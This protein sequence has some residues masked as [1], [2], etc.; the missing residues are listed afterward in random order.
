MR[1][2]IRSLMRCCAFILVALPAFAQT[3]H[4][5]VHRSQREQWFLRGRTL[6]GRPSAELLRRAHAQKLAL[7]AA[8]AANPANATPQNSSSWTSL[9]PAPL[10]SDASGIGQ[11]DYNWVSGRATAVA[12]DPADPSANTVYLGGAYGGVWKSTNATSP[13]PGNVI[14]T[15][16]IDDQATL[17]VGA[18]AIQPGGTGVIVVGTGEA[19]S[20]TDSYYGLGILLSSNAGATWTLI[21]SDSTGTR[22]FAGMAFSKIAFSTTTPSL[23]VAATAGASEGILEG[24]ANPVTANLGLYGSTDGG[25]Q[26]WT[27]GN[28]T[29]NGVTIDPGSA[30]AVVFNPGAGVFFAALRYHG[31]YSSPDGLNWI[32]L[33]NQPGAG[34]TTAACP[35]NPHSPACPIY[36]GEIAVVPGRNEMYAWY[37]DANN[38]DQGIWTSLDGGKTW[39]AINES[40]ITNCG[41]VTGCGTED[42][43]Y[44]LELAAVPD[45]GATDLYAGAVNLYK[46]QITSFS[47]TCAGTGQ[48]TFLNL[49]HAYGCSAIARVHPGQHAVAFQLTNSNTQD[50]MYFANDGGLYRALNGYT[51][52]TTGA[53]GSSNQF[54]SL[55]QT[56]GSMTQLVSF[57]QSATDPNTVLAGAGANGSPA[58]QSALSNSPWLNVNSGDGGNTQINPLDATDWFVSNPP[59]FTSGTNIFRCELGINCLT[60]DFQNDQVVNSATLG[61]DTGAYYPSFLLDPQ[62]SGELVVGTCRMWRGSSSGD[63]FTPL[64]NNFETGGSGICTGAETNL[65][66]SAAAAGPL[67]ANGFSNVMYAGTDGFGPLIPTIPSGGHVWVSTNVASGAVTWSDQTGAINPD[68]FPISGI[69]IDT[70]DPTGLTAYV[71]IMGFLVSHVWK[72]TNGGVSWMDFTANLPD[73]PANAVVV[74]PATNS[75]PGIIYVGTDVGVFSSRTASANW[76]EVGPAPS[77]GNP[78]F[79]PN[80]AVTTLQISNHAAAKLLRASTY[81]RGLWQF[82]VT[83]FAPTVLNNPIVAFPATLPATFSGFVSF[84]NYN[85][86]VNLTC[87]PPQQASCF[88][89]GSPVSAASPSFTVTASVTGT[90]ASY[91]FDLHAVGNDPNHSTQDTPLTLNL[92][93]FSLGP[94][95]AGSVTVPPGASSGPITFKVTLS[96][97]LPG[98]VTLS[99]LN[100]PQGV[101]CNFSPA[102]SPTLTPN[103]STQITLTLSVAANT[104]G[105]FPITVQ[106]LLQVTVGETVVA[107]PTPKTQNLS[108]VVPLDYALNISNPSLTVHEGNLAV[109][110]NGTLTSLN[111]YDSPVNLSCGMGAPPT[112]TAAPATVT[113]TANGSP[114]TVTVSTP[115]CGQYNFSILAAGTDPL[116]TSHS[117]PVI[118]VSNRPNPSFT[119]AISNSPLAADVSVPATFNGTLFASACYDY[120]VQ[121][122]CGSG[123]PP[124]CTAS[125]KVVTPTDTGAAFA[126]TVSSTTAQTYNFD[127]VGQGSDPS[128]LLSKQL[129]S[130]TSGSSAGSN[131]IFTLT[132]NSGAESVAAG[133]MATF[134]LIVAA[135]N[136]KLPDSVTINVSGCPAFSTCTPSPATVSAGEP[137]ASVALQIQT[138]TAIAIEHARPPSSRTPA[139][140]A[141]SLFLPGLLFTFSAGW[142]RRRG[143]GFFLSLV[144]MLIFLCCAL[145]CGGG[146]QGSSIADPQPGTTPS[147]YLLTVTAAMNSAPGS[148]T[149]TVVVVLT[150][151]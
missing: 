145:S 63:G 81:G 129:V 15:P 134:N 91:S 20:S 19:N 144:A 53:C 121:L 61:G 46:C 24:L 74:D 57:S 120:P 21:P 76:T 107:D 62:N 108:L 9:G 5:D 104:A 101:Q 148:P 128:A 18:I 95:S 73:A 131:S 147:T 64:S 49:T 23:A 67:D 2:S 60:P 133:Q 124:S 68:A 34:L 4:P 8:Q 90:D 83:G 43:A 33:T 30:T 42:G 110:F 37:V 146:L 48:N 70:S 87:V 109:F 118:F 6:P 93:D 56:L 100:P 47:P 123:S 65:V 111:G 88:V 10:S 102:S 52:L 97:P 17:A 35:P 41:D 71:T 94:L 127:I 139:L 80:L 143:S 7:R 142:P 86:S 79:L 25:G 28:V 66:R 119:V 69:A 117:F 126:V 114:F 99:C 96:G 112:C 113:P 39:A 116:R 89:T 150:V 58:T 38:N 13:S 137:S 72:T 136:G 140:Y 103:A 84:Y 27:Y 122:S 3:S 141:L 55:N 75:M 44:N 82:P 54:D 77:S 51:G 125:P 50:V 11:Q 149:Q 45:G 78:G 130:F 135:V 22:S 115:E 151:N 1:R 98:T 85:F 105:T 36:R 92:A 31:F 40:G 26:S 106:G 12:I 29:D 138:T 32:R 132:N 14:W 16:L 59:D